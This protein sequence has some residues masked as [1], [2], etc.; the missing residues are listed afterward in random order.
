MLS[1][2]RQ[3]DGD[4][5]VAQAAQQREAGS[6]TFGIR[7]RNREGH[8]SARLEPGVKGR[9]SQVCLRCGFASACAVIA[10]LGWTLRPTVSGGW[11]CRRGMAKRISVSVSPRNPEYRKAYQQLVSSGGLTEPAAREW[12]RVPTGRVAVLR[13]DLQ[14]VL[15]FLAETVFDGSF[16]GHSI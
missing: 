13:Q 10:V 7:A 14:A 5:A 15:G 11:S 4:V 12:S 2:V 9:I 1:C 16:S 6:H 8:E 3:G